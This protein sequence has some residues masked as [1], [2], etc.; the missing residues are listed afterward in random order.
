MEFESGAR[1]QLANPIEKLMYY[2][3]AVLLLAITAVMLYAVAM[4]YYFNR[5]PIW[6][7]EVPRMLF[8]WMVFIGAGIAIKQGLNVRVEYFVNMMPPA[9]RRWVETVMH[10]LALGLIAV[11]FFYSFPVVELSLG[12]RLLSTG[13]SN[14]VFTIPLPIGCVIMFCYQVGRL[15]KSWRPAGQAL[16]G[17]EG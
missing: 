4:R 5:P 15:R 11:L 7:E 1:D 3:A 12:G 13:W 6:S 14:A 10:A 16:P 17:T 8:V 2:A 9:L